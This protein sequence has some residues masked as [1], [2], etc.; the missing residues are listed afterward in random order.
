MRPPRPRGAAPLALGGRADDLVALDLGHLGRPLARAAADAV[1]EH[2][3][4]RLDEVRVRVGRQVV[5]GHA[6]DDAGHGDVHADLVG[7]GQHLGR[8]HGRVLGVGP[9]DGVRDAVADGDDARAAGDVDVLDEGA[10]V[11]RQRHGVPREER[12]HVD[13][14]DGLVAGHRSHDAGSDREDV[15]A[16]RA[17]EVDGVEGRRVGVVGQEAAGALG[18]EVGPAGRGQREGVRVRRRDAR[19][20]RY[21]VDD[22]RRDVDGGHVLGVDDA[23]VHARHRA[24]GE[25]EGR[26][27]PPRPARRLRDRLEAS[28]RLALGAE[29]AQDV[30]VRDAH[31]VGARALRGVDDRQDQVLG[32]EAEVRHGIVVV[33]PKVLAVEGLDGEGPA[34]AAARSPR[35]EDVHAGRRTHDD[36]VLRRLAGPAN[37]ELH[38][39]GK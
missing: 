23:H 35:V 17:A 2:P 18:A 15:R 38:V 24:Q 33:Q 22:V 3:L 36:A 5:R 37:L 21:D 29:L 39:S 25:G 34:A 28:D 1:D 27:G 14:A 32:V 12:G 20:R 19:A 26:A 10:V 7:H 11:E 16:L 31:V 9:E 4:P 13:G 30:A 6:L 8:G